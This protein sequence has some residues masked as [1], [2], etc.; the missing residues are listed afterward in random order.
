MTPLFLEDLKWCLKRTPKEV[1]TQLKMNPRRAFVA[2]GFIRACI[3]N[4]KINDIDIFVPDRETGYR[5]AKLLAISRIKDPNHLVQ[6][7][8]KIHETDNAFTIRGFL[9]AP[10][11]VHRWTF[12]KPE[13]CIESFDFTIACAAFWW[14][15]NNWQSVCDDRFYCDLAA[16]RLIYRAPVRNEDAGGSL[17]RVLKFYQ[18][19][20]RIPMD[21]LGR[22]I[23]RLNGAIDFNA[24]DRL[25]PNQREHQCARVVTGLLKEVDPD[26]DPHHVAHLPAE[27]ARETDNEGSHD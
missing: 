21:S 11:I 10:Q 20:Y 9:I 8:Q 6:Y 12:E 1:L 24:I 18:R 17:L 5:L 26:I 16:K 25:A 7:H 23:A 22:V 27:D 2:G 14:D 3:A 15:G 19:G 4:E 13:Q